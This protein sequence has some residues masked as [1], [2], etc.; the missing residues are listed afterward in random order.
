MTAPHART[1]PDKRVLVIEDDQ[2]LRALLEFVLDLEEGIDVETLGDE[3]QAV[4]VCRRYQPDVVV[5]DLRLPHVSGEE[6][7]TQVRSEQPGV[8]IIS[9]S[10]FDASDRPWADDQ[11]VKN[12]SLIEDLNRA[13][14]DRTSSSAG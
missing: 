7:A 4:E 5:I 12:V 3:R 1:T 6:V 14:A 10:G 13:I 9:M 8:R 11:V 2:H